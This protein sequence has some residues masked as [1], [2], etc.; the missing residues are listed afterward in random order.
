MLALLAL[1]FIHHTTGQEVIGWWRWTWGN[2]GTPPSGCNVGI[3]FSGEINV[4]SAI[5]ESK[6]VYNNLPGAKYIDLGGGDSSGR[7]S[8]SALNSI[9]SA[10][11]N[12]SFSAYKGIAFDVEEGDSGLSSQ[13]NTAFAAAKSHGY[14]VIVTVSNSAPYGFSDAATLMHDFFSNTN[15]DYL[16]PQLYESGEESQNNYATSAGIGWNQYAGAHAKTIPSIVQAS[17]YNDAV[18]YFKGQGVTLYGF[19]QWKN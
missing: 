12:G 8:S 17:Y 16:S 10:I 1:L 5:S 9:I 19:I 6:A 3:A 18:N 13:F 15:I 11:N 2:G 4:N 7:W 14:T